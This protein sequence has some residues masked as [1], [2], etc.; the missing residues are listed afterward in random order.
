MDAST[1]QAG[2]GLVLL[3]DSD[4]AALSESLVALANAEGGRIVIGVDPASKEPVGVLPASVE[5]DLRAAQTHTSP[6]IPAEWEE[7]EADDRTVVILQISA[8]RHLHSLLDGRVLRRSGSVNRVLLGPE[9]QSLVR[10]RPSVRK[11]EESVFG[12]AYADLDQEVIREYLVLRQ[13]KS[14][15]QGVMPIKERL[16]QLG[17]LDP[18]QCPTLSG[19][20][21]FG[22]HPQAFLPHAKIVFVNFKDVPAA[23]GGP[24]RD[25]RR[26]ARRE[27]I[28][29]HLAHVITTTYNVVRQEMAKYSLVRGLERIDRTEY[30]LSVVREALVNAVAH[31][32][33]GLTGRS[34][35]VRM[36]ENALE[37]IS[38]GGL[39]A[40][41]TLDNILDE[42]YS[43]NPAIVNGLY[44]WGYIEELGLGID[45]IYNDLLQH[46]H[47]PPEFSAAPH[48]FSVKMYSADAAATLPAAEQ[49]AL[50]DRQ[51]TAVRYVQTHGS[52]SNREYQAECPA[53]SPETLR[54]D[55]VKLVEGGILLRIGEKRGTRY[56]LKTAA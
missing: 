52:I 8:S 54:L 49:I 29:G 46:G 56:I 50:N 25:E 37:I 15:W 43:R 21:L 40:H 55:L 26:Y 23:A 41:M 9:L 34:I 27:E 5:Q 32:D 51:R 3:R 24:A 11:E 31:R 22:K 39:P 33:Y 28:T 38:P 17:A 10:V 47:P 13:Q 4:A 7:E 20:L 42:H 45:L 2:A 19:L 1:L 6:F 30:P 36:H 16:Q 35:E 44:Q 48:K 12:A 14:Q 53:V 18:D